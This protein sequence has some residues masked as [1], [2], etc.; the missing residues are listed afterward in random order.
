MS[1]DDIL[2]L[3][4]RLEHSTITTAEFEQGGAVLRLRFGDF[5]AKAT[6]LDTEPAALPSALTSDMP[7][8][9]AAAAGIFHAGHPLEPHLATPRQ[10]ITGQT[11]GFLNLGN[12]MQAVTAHRDG[13]LSTPQVPDGTLV[14][15]G[16]TLFTIT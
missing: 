7:G 2:F 15:Y 11:V 1:P 10:V 4:R 12:A 9:C 3:I 16:Q 8:I 6:R 14:G 13:V 5:Q